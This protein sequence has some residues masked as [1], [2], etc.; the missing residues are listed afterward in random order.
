MGAG[1]SGASSGSNRPGGSASPGAASDRSSP[2]PG[3][4]SNRGS[5][6]SPGASSNRGSS[7]SPGAGSNR[8]SSPSPG[9]GTSRSGPAS[10][11]R[12]SQGFGR[13]DTPSSGRSSLGGKGRAG[14]GGNF[15]GPLGPN[16]ELR[17]GITPGLR[18]Y[19]NA[20]V[21]RAAYPDTFGRYTQ[22]QV[23]D[24]MGRLAQVAPPEA[25]TAK[26]GTSPLASISRV[27]MNQVLA[28]RS[29]NQAMAA[30]DS[31]RMRV[32]TRNVQTQGLAAPGTPV[33]TSAQMAI[34]DAMFGRGVFAPA[35]NAN[36]FTAAGTPLKGTTPLGDYMGTTYRDDPAFSSRI[37]AANQKAANIM[38]GTFIDKGQ[39]A[40][41]AVAAGSFAQPIPK[42]REELAGLTGSM[43]SLVRSRPTELAGAFPAAGKQITDRIAPEVAYGKQI[44]DRLPQEQSVAINSYGKQIT[45]RIAPEPTV[46]GRPDIPANGFVSRVAGRPET[47]GSGFPARSPQLAGLGISRTAYDTG[48]GI[49]GFGSPSAYGGGPG[50]QGIVQGREYAGTPRRAVQISSYDRVEPA[51]EPEIK[52]GRAP[53]GLAFDLG[54]DREGKNNG[55]R[56]RIAQALMQRRNS[57]A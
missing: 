29:L 45:D 49:V 26:Y 34:Q 4:S 14:F 7:P 17:T 25:Y 44:T 57:Y 22:Q 20:E 55:W 16:G 24:F 40:P 11:G 46:A 35:M 33:N 53:I 54:F 6:A 48:S 18:N 21:A 12:D 38:G 15:R 50:P 52:R 1:R 9:A 31:S 2:S 10:S 41:T 13:D 51:A 8:G 42:S 36:N 5:S 30:L 56:R 28:G 3:A 23:T 37:A 32:G 39:P 43:P 47:V 27:A 19:Q